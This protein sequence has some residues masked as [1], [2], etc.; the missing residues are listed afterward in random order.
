MDAH[1]VAFLLTDTRE[2]R[3]LPTL[4]CAARGRLAINAALGFSG[5]V[6]MRHGAPLPP[7]AP[8]PEQ[9]APL[10][11][12]RAA[13]QGARHAAVAQGGG[14][15]QQAAGQMHLQPQAVAGQQAGQQEEAGR[16]EPPEE[17]EDGSKGAAGTAAGLADLSLAEP[18][19]PQPIQQQREQQQQLEREQGAA[20]QA[21]S[22]DGASAC[23]APRGQAAAAPPMAAPPPRFGCYFCND[24]VAPLDSTRDRSLDQQCTV[25]G[26][27]S[28]TGHA[29]GI[30]GHNMLPDRGWHPACLHVAAIFS[31]SR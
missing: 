21:G 6:V 16:E 19:H 29:G 3:W 28:G 15:Q 8:A 24:V 17:Q 25:G 13:D 14:E 4:L 31:S 7:E 10:Q 20:L 2:S 30:H 9:Q 26:C 1:D 5:F 18:E 22:G 11:Q 12:G 23:A 27:V